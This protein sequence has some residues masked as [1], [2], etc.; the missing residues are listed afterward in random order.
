MRAP[1]RIG[2]TAG[3]ALVLFAGAGVGPRSAAAEDAYPSRPIRL[4]VPFG[5]GGIADIHSRITAGEL[6]TRLGQ[7]VVIENRPGGFGIPA[8]QSVL[9]GA[10][11]GYS[12]K[13][14]ANGTATSVSLL[15]NLTFDPVRDFAPV[16]NLVTFD[17][18]I[19]VG[20]K[21]NYKTLAD[22]IA[23]A[24]ANPGK[25]NV[26]TTAKGSTS[27]LA[28]E[29]LKLTTGVDFTVIAY[30]GAS[31]MVV[32]LLRGDVDL[33][34]DSYA[35]LKAAMES[36]G[37]RPIASTGA[38]RSVVLPE[39]PTVIE[40]GIKDFDVTSWNGVFVKAGTPP[41][42]IAKLNRELQVIQSQPGLK[43]RLRELGLEASPSAPEELGARLK[44]DIDKWAT[45]IGKLGIPKQ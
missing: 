24:R 25:L 38:K 6:S 3:L 19:V 34:L 20:T 13:L 33:V 27:N 30:R 40:S 10:P 45:V 28:A 12:L 7:Q 23:A 11:D 9:S 44:S 43:Q 32:G 41:A 31:D 2:L 37:A 29:L 26:G 5:A 17:F 21:S 39:V 4:V 8:A 22:V 15:K 36:D 1:I 18:L 42:V 14:F 35:A 16:S